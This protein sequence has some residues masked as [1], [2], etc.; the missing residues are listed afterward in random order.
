ML[1]VFI[2]NLSNSLPGSYDRL[3][4]TIRQRILPPEPIT[5]LERKQTLTRLE[6]IIQ[7]RL[8]TSEL[9]PQMRTSRVSKED[10]SFLFVTFT[11][12]IFL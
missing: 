6:Q 11:L 9:P 2:S 7:H 8:V 5:P 10:K 12:C 3:P 1:H 4:L